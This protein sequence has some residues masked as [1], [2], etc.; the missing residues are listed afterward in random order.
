MLGFFA[1]PAVTI[2]AIGNVMRW[3]Q[4]PLYRQ[5]DIYARPGTI[6][7]MRFMRDTG[8]IA[9]ASSTSLE[10]RIF[11]LIPG[12]EENVAPAAKSGDGDDDVSA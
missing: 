6:G 3:L 5:A 10:F 2:G 4:R 11:Q 7:G 8:F 1:S 12:L 9:S